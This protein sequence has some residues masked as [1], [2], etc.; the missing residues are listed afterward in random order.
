M[1]HTTPPSMEITCMNHATEELNFL[2][3]GSVDL[4]VSAQAAHWFDYAKLWVQLAHVLRKDVSVAFWGYS[5][6]QIAG[7]P[8]L[9]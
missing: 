3:T 7:Y 9:T 8:G 5:Q 6:F 2:K 4:V 1:P